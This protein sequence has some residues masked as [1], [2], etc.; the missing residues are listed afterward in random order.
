M[1]TAS[2]AATP[3]G[4][5]GTGIIGAVTAAAN[6]RHTPCPAW[7]PPAPD[8]FE[9]ESYEH[10]RRRFHLWLRGE[11]ENATKYPNIVR[12]F[13]LAIQGPAQDHILE[14]ITDDELYTPARLATGT[15]G[16]PG[17]VYI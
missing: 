8:D 9:A 16:D 15:E 5:G 14:N 12:E 4:G 13:T 11:I 1:A 7:T 17:Y 10:W 3:P 6:R 2:P